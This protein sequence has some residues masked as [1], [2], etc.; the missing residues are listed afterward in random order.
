M[1]DGDEGVEVGPARCG[2]EGVNDFPLTADV[3][4]YCMRLGS[5][6]PAPCPAGKLPGSSAGTSLVGTMIAAL[7]TNR[8]PAGTW[9]ND[10]VTS[11]FHGER[12]TYAVVA[13][14]VAVIATGGALALT[15]SRSTDEGQD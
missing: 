15:D 4:Y 11:F 14:I 3:G 13:V 1:Q 2:E 7:V 8:L 10:L 6:H 9:S 12:I 5:L